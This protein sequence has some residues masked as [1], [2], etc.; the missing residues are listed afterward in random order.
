MRYLPAIPG[1]LLVLTLLVP[2]AVGAQP[3]LERSP[4][5]R[6]DS[7]PPRALNVLAMRAKSADRV[8]AQEAE[9]RRWAA[10][11]PTSPAPRLALAELARFDLRYD[12]GL[13]W[14]DSA[15]RLATTAPWRSAVARE[16]LASRL[17]RGEFVGTDSMVRAL[18]AD[19]AGLPGSEK[20]EVL[21]LRTGHQ[22]RLGRPVTMSIVDTMASMISPTD[23]SMRTRLHCFR[24]MADPAGALQHADSSI[25]MAFAMGLPSVAATCQLTVATMYV[26]AGQM[27]PAERWLQRAESTSRAAHDD[28]TLAATLQWHGY[29]Q[30]TLGYVQSARRWNTEAIRVSQRSSNRNVEAWALLGVASAARDVGDAGTANTALARASALFGATGDNIGALNARV[31][32]AQALI[33]VRDLEGAERLALSTRLESDSLRYLSGALRSLYLLSDIAL[34]RGQL[35]TCATLLDQAATYAG[36]LGASWLTQVTEYRG[37]LAQQRGDTP[38]AIGLLTQ[39]RTAYQQGQ[40]LYLHNIDG[41]LALAWLNAGDTAKSAALLDESSRRLDAV[42]DTLALAKL[43]KVVGTIDYWGGTNGNIDQAMAAFVTSPKWLP[44]VFMVTERSRARALL[45]GA[46]ANESDTSVA[47]IGAARQRIRAN[48]TVLADV[49]RALKPNTALLIYAGGHGGARTS[50]M[51]VT[52]TTARGFT[53]APLDSLDRDIVRWLALLES[54]E[55]GAGA[56]RRVAGAVLGNALRALPSPIRRLVIVPHG[57]LYRVPFQALPVANGVL[58]DRVVVTISPSVSLAMAYAADPRSVQ[59]RVLALGAGDTRVQS[60]VPQSLEL[61]AERAARSNPLSPLLAAG[62]EARAAAGWAVGSLALTGTDASETAL[63]REARHTYSVLHTAAHALTSDQALGANYLILRPDSEDD[64]YVSGGELAS[65]STGM[66]MV[67]LSGCRTTG[68]FGSRGDAVDGLVAPLLARGVRTVV[69]SHWAVSDRWTKVLMERFYERLAA[70]VGAADAMNDA[71]R[72]LR[73]AGVPARFWA[74][75]SVIGDGSLS[76]TAT[77]ALPTR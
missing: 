18:V 42:R 57:P 68:D 39:V 56:G 50:V 23:S 41:A 37:M 6:L 63:K 44:T 74:A 28:P 38:R 24:A 36:R 66:S 60:D 71:Q 64:G 7:L 43:R 15:A 49:Q 19:T 26:G 52:R 14:A 47:E 22:R 29:Q 12:D 1:S 46:I 40:D 5:Q 67:V 62:E 13:A 35:D 48:A 34:R 72:T 16:R 58:G 61:V 70:G 8:A 11:S 53:L 75:F 25:L 65:L 45:S 59:A 76:F 21:Y 2:S 9:W 30:R 17:V 10:A 32:Q 27:Q 51:L 69:A 31:E 73:R 77:A 20:A 33:I 3:A 54:G 4:F 55:T